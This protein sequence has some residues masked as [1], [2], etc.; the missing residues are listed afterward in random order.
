MVHISG[1]WRRGRFNRTEVKKLVTT[2]YDSKLPHGLWHQALETAT[3]LINR[4][5]MSALI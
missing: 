2:L 1:E 5:P 3:Y 4:S